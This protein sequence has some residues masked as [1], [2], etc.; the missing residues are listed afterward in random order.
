MKVAFLDCF[1]GISGDMM[2]GA[3][4]DLGFSESALREG[5]AGLPLSGYRIRVSRQKRQGLEGT[6]VEVQVEQDNQPRR[7]YAA[8]REIL[9]NS[10]LSE[11]V[12]KMAGAVFE[13]LARAEARV[14]DKPM[15]QVHFHEVGAVDSIVDIVGAAMGLE[16]LGVETCFVSTLPLGSGFV[17]CS[18]GILPV[19]APA[20][21]EL[22]RGM[23]VKDHPAEAELTTPTG[24]AIAS[25]L[26]GPEHPPLPPLR[27]ERVGYGVGSRDLDFPNMLRIYLGTLADGYEEDAVQVLECQVDDLQPEVYPYLMEKLL[28]AGALD[29]SLIPIQMKKGRPGIL[30]QVLVDSMADSLRFTEILFSETTTLGVRLA[31]ANRIKLLR[32][33]DEVKTPLGPVSVKVVQ[34]SCLKE[35]EVRPEYEACK[36]IASEKGVPLRRVYEEVMRNADLSKTA[37]KPIKK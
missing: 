26:A 10:P 5:L 24:A 15:D 32:R 36:R 31:A 7:D 34:G 8:I 6:R 17:H 23:R 11:R 3:L 2:L 21:T 12:R 35:P 20:T 29:V 37:K 1:S 25:C 19:P 16:A 18:H 28:E 9:V 4:L 22:L 14:H 33:K 27:I 13:R 30:V